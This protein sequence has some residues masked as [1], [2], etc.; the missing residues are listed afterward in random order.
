MLSYNDQL[1]CLLPIFVAILLRAIFCVILFII[2]IKFQTISPLKNLLLCD[3]S[4]LSFCFHKIIPVWLYNHSPFAKISI[5]LTFL[6]YCY[7]R[8]FCFLTSVCY[9]LHLTYAS[10]VSAVQAPL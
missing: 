5:I 10:C 7:S 3:F 1:C 6:E 4:P 8:F 9:E 2:H